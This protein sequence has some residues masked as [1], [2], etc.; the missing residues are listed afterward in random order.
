MDSRPS[1][2]ELWIEWVTP[3]ILDTFSIYLTANPI[4]TNLVETLPLN[5]GGTTPLLAVFGGVMTFALNMFMIPYVRRFVHETGVSDTPLFRS[6]WL[7]ICAC[8]V[9]RYTASNSIMTFTVVTFIPYVYIRVRHQLAACA[10]VYALIFLLLTCNNFVDPFRF[11]EGPAR[12]FNQNDV[13]NIMVHTYV[14]VLSSLYHIARFETHKYTSN[15][16]SCLLLPWR[17][18]AIPLATFRTIVVMV[19]IL[20]GNGGFAS[21]ISST[22]HTYYKYM[23]VLFLLSAISTYTAWTHCQHNHKHRLQNILATSVFT[24]SFGSLVSNMEQIFF[25][26]TIFYLVIFIDIFNITGSKKKSHAV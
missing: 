24:S 8:A 26:W 18:S 21:D 1:R 6:V 17:N 11:E 20:S 13:Y 7:F 15:P 16:K 9:N 22:T 10:A 23:C 12:P 2:T 14:F 3:L 4:T 19:C 5:A 25:A